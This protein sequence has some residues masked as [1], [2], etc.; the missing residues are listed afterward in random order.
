MHLVAVTRERH[1]E[2][3]W[4]AP[5][6]YGF[7][8]TQALIP[9]V[10]R[11]FSAAAVAMPIALVE[12]AGRYVP[13]AVLS[14]VQGRNLFVTSTRRW[15]GLYQPAALRSYPF[16]LAVLKGSNQVSLCVDEDSGWVIDANTDPS[17]PRFFEG[18]GTPSAALKATA[19]F[20]QKVE[21]SR[22][23]TEAAIAAL[24]DARLIQP[25]PLAVT[26]G[27][28]RSAASGLYR[29]AVML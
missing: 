20:L 13:V 4:R 10:G 26:L 1:S 5:G 15:L 19:E 18:D 16:R 3:R 8:A 14:P 9:L 2:K 17:A 6:R 28:Q 24:A 27:K 12:Q 22:F 25:W 29:I 7:A 21:H 23:Q 11:E